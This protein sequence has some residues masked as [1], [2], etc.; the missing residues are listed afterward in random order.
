LNA[1]LID[2]EAHFGG[3]K[4]DKK[5][6]KTNGVLQIPV[7]KTCMFGRSAKWN[8]VQKVTHREIGKC[9]KHQWFSTILDARHVKRHAA[10]NGK[11]YK[12]NGFSTIFT[13]KVLQIFANFCNFLQTFLTASSSRSGE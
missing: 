2:K 6:L 1:I 8:F 13:K 4:K 3:P 5:A 11:H 9:Y 12:T 7:S 10:E